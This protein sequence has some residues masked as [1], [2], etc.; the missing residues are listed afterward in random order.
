MAGCH[1]D[2][3]GPKPRRAVSPRRALAHDRHIDRFGELDQFGRV[4]VGDDVPLALDAGHPQFVLEAQ[5]DAVGD[6]GFVRDFGNTAPPG[7]GPSTKPARGSCRAHR[8][9]RSGRA[10][11]CSGPPRHMLRRGVLW[12]VRARLNASL[13]RASPAMVGSSTQTRRSLSAIAASLNVTEFRFVKR[14]RELCVPGSGVDAFSSR[15][16]E[17]SQIWQARPPQNFVDDLSKR[18]ARAVR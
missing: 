13:R 6:L 11:R 3:V 15:F 1:H 7:L 2:I 14:R 17:Q 9:S 5:L 8:R 10:V 12:S 16:G 18:V 4:A